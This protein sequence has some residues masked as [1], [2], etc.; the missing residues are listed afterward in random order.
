M[1]EGPGP[2]FGIRR[3]ES[4]TPPF[5]GLIAA[6]HR[7]GMIDI[8][9]DGRVVGRHQAVEVGFDAS[10]ASGSRKVRYALSLG[11]L[12]S[13][14]AAGHDSG[15][16]TSRPR[17]CTVAKSDPAHSL[18]L[19]PRQLGNREQPQKRWPARSPF[20]TVRKLMLAPHLGHSA[21]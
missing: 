5:F 14:H 3:L 4:A 11:K 19:V 12:H 1:G 16:G 17:V 6:D 7:R 21:P 13:L 20:R 15:S 8:L 9:S 10:A 18:Q 2:L